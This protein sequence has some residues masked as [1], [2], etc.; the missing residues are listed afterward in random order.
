MSLD[1]INLFHYAVLKYWRVFFITFK[2]ISKKLYSVAL[3]VRSRALFLLRRSL[4]SK[5]MRTKNILLYQHT[6]VCDAAI[7][8]HCKLSYSLH[9]SFFR[10]LILI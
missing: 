1:K 8:L 2:A 4:A 3:T 7:L 5:K 6:T 10:L 9:F